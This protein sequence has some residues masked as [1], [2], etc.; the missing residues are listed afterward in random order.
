M[1]QIQNCKRYVL[2]RIISMSIL[3]LF[4]IDKA[5]AQ[6]S[7]LDSIYFK[8]VFTAPLYSAYWLY[9]GTWYVNDSVQSRENLNT[10]LHK[11]FVFNNNEYY[12]SFSKIQTSDSLL[13]VINVNETMNDY[14]LIDSN[15]A[16][17]QKDPLHYLDFSLNSKTARAYCTYSARLQPPSDHHNTAV[18]VIPG[19]GDNTTTDVMRNIG[20]NCTY[21]DVKTAL[22]E[23]SDVYILN[24]PLQD[25]RAIYWN[26]KRLEAEYTSNDSLTIVNELF[27]K[28]LL[29]GT[30]ITIETI[31]M[32]KYLKQHYDYV[33]VT[34]LSHGA[35]I[36]YFA[37]IEAEPDALLYSGG[38]GYDE[39]TFKY[40]KK[41]FSSIMNLFIP[42]TMAKLISESNAFHCYSIADVDL[43]V[44]ISYIDQ[45]QNVF[46]DFDKIQHSFPKCYVFKNLLDSVYK[47]VKPNLT[48][49]SKMKD[50]I[51]ATFIGSPPFSFD[52]YH[53]ANKLLSYQTNSYELFIPIIHSGVYQIKNCVGS[54]NGL[55]SFSNKVNFIS[56][57]PELYFGLA[58]LEIF[59][60][61]GTR[62]VRKEILYDSNNFSPQK[63]LS[64]FES[65]IYLFVVTY[66]TNRRK[67][68]KF[69]VTN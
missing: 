54:D 18:L 8:S 29:Y 56:S 61:S 38:I 5:E 67:E 34:G 55:Q 52:L 7:A 60:I 51:K 23:W 69:V 64:H 68:G 45:H 16:F 39:T 36:A 14:Y 2:L 53:N 13:P 66:G 35:F 41:Y 62:I 47:R 26:Q 48:V 46:F 21:C 31:A 37:T 50:T 15:Y 28:D 58:Q 40:Q 42:D 10:Q 57:N 27:A 3:T 4:I 17:Q 1:S 12:G 20:Y 32:I 22:S 63:F 24:K 25:C 49:I 44:G 43:K 11:Q 6:L 19:S 59:S 33:I 30:N 9:P 65:G